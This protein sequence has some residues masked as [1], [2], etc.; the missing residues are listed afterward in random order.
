MEKCLFCQI[1]DKQISS[2]LAYEDDQIIAF[3]D[4]N[5]KAPVHI[6]L[7]PKKHFASLNEMKERDKELLGHLIYQAKV[8][9]QNKGINEKGYRIII[10]T[11]QYAGQEVKHL[12]VHL[13]GG[14]PM[15]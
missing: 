4:I 11:G 7:V 6:L 5:P 9:A 3:C 8:L 2:R 1:A 14:K 12:H 10:N 15:K 13:L